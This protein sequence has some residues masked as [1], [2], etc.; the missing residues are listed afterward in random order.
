MRD[1][2]VLKTFV[3]PLS[4][5]LLLVLPIKNLSPAVSRAFG[6]RGVRLVPRLLNYISLLRIYVPLPLLV[7][8]PS[9]RLQNHLSFRG[10]GPWVCRVH[11]C[12]ALTGNLIF[13]SEA[14]KWRPEHCRTTKGSMRL[15]MMFA[16]KGATKSRPGY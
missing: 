2:D 10:S 1:I 13:G 9:P 6:Y 8:P 12:S 7:L 14:L 4:C 5:V 11:W 3:Q 15:Y 16:L